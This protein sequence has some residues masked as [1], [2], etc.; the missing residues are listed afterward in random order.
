MR[1]E[2]THFSRYKALY[3][4]GAIDVA[5]L[6]AARGIFSENFDWPAWV[7]AVGSISAILA[8]VWVSSDQASQQRRLDEIR[9]SNE[10]DGV[11]R[12]IKSEVE[13]SLEYLKREVA[14][15]LAQV[16]RGD[17]IR[18]TFRLPEYPFPIF[19]GLIPKLGILPTPLRSQVIRAYAQAK[20]LAVTT[21]VHDDLASAFERV[22]IRFLAKPPSAGDLE[23]RGALQSLTDYSNAFR[24][25]FDNTMREF[26]G[27]HEDLS[28]ACPEE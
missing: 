24:L 18:Y 4:L 6:I 5:A 16:P 26:V 17:P 12:S 10:V 15:A 7:Q 27:L 21:Q 9:E 14:P 3:I 1:T 22:E 19:D 20:T 11:L 8:A 25:A 28:Q 13:T 2:I 23:L